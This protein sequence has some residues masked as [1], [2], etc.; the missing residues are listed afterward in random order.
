MKTI[1]IAGVLSAEEKELVERANILFRDYTEI[2]NTELVSRTNKAADKAEIVKQLQALF[3][4][5]RSDIVNGSVLLYDYSLI[6]RAAL[7]LNPDHFFI[8]LDSV[9]SVDRGEDPKEIDS[10]LQDVSGRSA[11]SCAIARSDSGVQ[12]AIRLLD[13]KFLIGDG[14]IYGMPAIVYLATHSSEKFLKEF[15]HSSA[16]EKIDINAKDVNGESSIA[17]AMARP[18]S[19]G[20]GVTAVL[21]EVLLSRKIALPNPD[22]SI[23]AAQHFSAKDFRQ[24][25]DKGGIDFSMRAETKEDVLSH[26]MSR[27]LRENFSKNAARA[28]L[29]I[30]KTLINCPQV[31]LALPRNYTGIFSIP[32]FL[33]AAYVGDLDLIREF[34][35]QKGR[36][37]PDVRDENGNSALYYVL[38]NPE[39]C[40]DNTSERIL[41][42][43]SDCGFKVSKGDLKPLAKEVK[44]KIEFFL[45]N[46]PDVKAPAP[47][48]ATPA[49]SRP[50]SRASSLEGVS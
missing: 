17:I 11:L 3:H 31:D 20:P 46:Y 37:N 12:I 30:A 39:N 42:N 8:I 33:Y 9:K 6:T 47:S 13:E 22:S 4:G 23:Y 49:A 7:S 24:I 19:E 28:G 27:V 21:A 40:K 26:A 45:L 50:Q 2:T 43:L 36:F 48:V 32:P 44:E 10:V 18:D 41:I 38:L 34:G 5:Q 16:A 25:L 35:K 15:L 14:N 1:E 29:D